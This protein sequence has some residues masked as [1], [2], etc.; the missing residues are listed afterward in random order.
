MISRRGRAD[1]SDGERYCGYG[2]TTFQSLSIR[3]TF[4]L[5]APF[6]SPGGRLRCM[7]TPVMNSCQCGVRNRGRIVG[8]SETLVNEY[9][10][11]AGIVDSTIKSVYCGATISKIIF[12]FP[13]FESQKLIFSLP[14]S[15]SVAVTAAHCLSGKDVSALALLVG[16]HDTTTGTDTPYGALYKIKHYEIHFMF[17]GTVSPMLHDIGLVWTDNPLTFS[18]GVGPA[19]LPFKF[20]RVT[21]DGAQ[22][23]AAGW[24][25]LDFGE[26][27]LGV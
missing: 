13:K 4:S 1:L 21:F 19:C 3:A 8:G 25:L 12:N 6:N 20:D 23:I 18:R 14:V 9:P 16:D 22:V 26:H 10:M 27:F 2:S 17:N 5:Q 24:G 15:E 11:M 7:V